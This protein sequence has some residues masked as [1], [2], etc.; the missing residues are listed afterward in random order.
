MGRGQEGRDLMRQ[1]RVAAFE[2]YE[3]MDVNNISYRCTLNSQA[4]SFHKMILI[5][6][7]N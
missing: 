3:D 5:T 6:V 7:A 1:A 4:L 2:L